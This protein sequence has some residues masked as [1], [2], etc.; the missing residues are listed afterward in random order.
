MK[1]PHV[2]QNLGHTKKADQGSEFLAGLVGGASP[3]LGVGGLGPAAYGLADT[4]NIESAARIGGRSLLESILGAIA[5]GGAGGLVGHRAAQ[6]LLRKGS[7]PAFEA[8]KL[9]R[10]ATADDI[11]KLRDLPI[12]G[13]LIGGVGGSVL[14]GAHG[15]SAAMENHNERDSLIQWLK[16]R[17]E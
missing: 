8:G 2:I 1:V 10:L 7:N 4:R 16:A 17:M 13:A 6:S 15:A 14:G 11:G 9:H 12:A 5:L 3:L